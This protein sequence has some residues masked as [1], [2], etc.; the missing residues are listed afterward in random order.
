MASLALLWLVFFLRKSAALQGAHRK[1]THA[2]A[3]EHEH[4]ERNVALRTRELADL[5]LHLQTLREGERGRLA[6]S[7]HDE[8]GA[9]LTAAKLDVTRLRRSAEPLGQA[10]QERLQHLA[11]EIDSGI[12]IKRRMMEKLMPPALHNLGLR[13]ALEILANEFRSRKDVALQTDLEPVEADEAARNALFRV[14][15]ESLRNAEQYADATRITMRLST[16]NGFAIVEIHDNGK[17]FDT[18]QSSLP[19]VAAPGEAG[20]GRGL[21]QLQYRLQLAGG[22]FSVTSSASQGTTIRASVPLSSATN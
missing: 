21:K 22:Q 8:L 9:T 14:A 13:T 19:P 10:L 4:L 5:N 6:R 20:A 1:H 17:G 3:E 7:L 15:Q 16:A 12:S 2:I 11:T 18:R